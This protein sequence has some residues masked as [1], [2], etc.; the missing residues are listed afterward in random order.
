MSRSQVFSTVFTVFAV[1][2]QGAC[3]AVLGFNDFSVNVDAADGGVLGTPMCTSNRACTE[4]SGAPMDASNGAVAVPSICLKKTGQCVPLLSDDCNVITGDYLDDS[5]IVIGSLFSTT[6]AQASTNLARQ[7]S[8]TLAVEEINAAGGIPSGT[9]S[10]D[11]RPLVMVSCDESVNLMRAG[12]HLTTELQV[13]AIVGPNTSQDTLDVSN[14]LTIAAGTLVLSPTAVASSIADLLDNG[15][16]WQIIPTDVQRAPLMIQEINTLESRLRADRNRQN[17]KLSIIYRDDALGQGTRVSLNALMLNGKPLADPINLGSNVRIDPYDFKQPNQ[18]PIVDANVK[19]APD[20]IVLAGPAESVTSVMVPLEQ[21]WQG[22]LESRPEYVLIDSAKV[23]ELLTAVMGNDDLRRR[24]RGTGVTPGMRSVTVNDTFQVSYATRYPNSPANIFGMGPAYD[25][26][27]AIA[28]AIASLRGA[29]I[30]GANIGLGLR[31]LA[32]GS[33]SVEVQST[34][35]L[36][37]FRK[38]TAGEPLTVIGTF[39]TLQWSDNGA[40]LGG[41]IELWCIANPN[42]KPTFDQS[43]LMFDTQSG[44]S[45]GKYQ[46]CGDP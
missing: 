4:H 23:P 26:T 33:T 28:Y 14:K 1:I 17:I 9:T 19:F 45:F 5:A 44:Q 8:A 31:R 41:T 32:G 7:Q 37:A 40:I 35:I 22:P 42:G 30:T 10:A 46:Q 6:G 34:K 25:S 29:D 12:S 38:L 18:Q 43:G 27:Y 24:V 39:A 2:T 3:S 21:A 15:L 13:P 36:A 20:I 16:T 11:A